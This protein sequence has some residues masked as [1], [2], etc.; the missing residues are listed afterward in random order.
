MSWFDSADAILFHHQMDGFTGT[1]NLRAFVLDNHQVQIWKD[2]A[3]WKTFTNPSQLEE[4]HRAIGLLASFSM[5]QTVKG[6]RARVTSIKV[7]N[8]KGRLPFTTYRFR[9]SLLDLIAPSLTVV[10]FLLELVSSPPASFLFT[11]SLYIAPI[12]AAYAMLVFLFWCFSGCQPFSTWSRRSTLTSWV[13]KDD[14]RKK[15]RPG[16]WGPAGPVFDGARNGVDEEHALP[17]TRS[18]LDWRIRSTS[19][20]E[21]D[22]EYHSR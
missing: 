12:L 11:V 14:K 8:V 20:K 22:A 21:T 10:L 5:V 17:L 7:S 18:Q 15:S 4:E 1:I 2:T 13:R 16:I 3:S 9:T 19:Q 6:A